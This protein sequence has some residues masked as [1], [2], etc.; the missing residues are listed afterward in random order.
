MADQH[1]KG[2]D[3]NVVVESQAANRA[4]ETM[5]DGRDSTPISITLMKIDGA[6]LSH[7][8]NMQLSVEDDNKQIQVPVEYANAER[9]KQVRKD[10]YLR[11]TAGRMQTPIV[12]F[13]RTSMARSS[14]ATP[15]NQHLD[16]TYQTGWNRHN[17]YDKFAV[18]NRITPSRETV[19]VM[20]PD[21]I[22]VT[23]EY[24]IWTDYVDQ[25]NDLIQKISFEA[26]QYWGDRNDFKFAVRV[27]DYT[28]E[29]DV[30]AEGDRIVKTAFSMLVHAYLLPD[31]TYDI[32]RGFAASSQK[33]YTTKKHIT[34]IEV[35]LALS[36]HGGTHDKADTELA[37][38]FNVSSSLSP[39]PIVL[40]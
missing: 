30:P 28:T 36:G 23:Y 38:A 22:N 19:S 34:V 4:D 10:G 9:W 21:Y 24:L 11:D 17:S 40:E 8:R 32:D 31:T 16:R 5:M 26:D 15:M 2:Y 14:L 35:D 25:M 13:R 20:V 7:L 39:T 18:L 29:T 33:R 12:L 3:R 1:L 6:I 27:D 37:G